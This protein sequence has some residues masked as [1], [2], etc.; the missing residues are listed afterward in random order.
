M[1]QPKKKLPRYNTTGQNCYVCGN[2]A[3]RY[4]RHLDNN[5]TIIKCQECGLEYTDPIPSEPVL[6]LFYEKYKDIRAD[7][8]I[9]E[10]NAHEHLKLLKKYGW[11]QGSKT[12]DFGAGTGVFVEV[13]G[14]NCYGVDLQSNSCPRIKQSLKEFSDI[15]WDFIVLWGVL[16]HLPNPQK[17]IC[18]LVDRLKM[19]GVLALTT[20][21]AEGVIPYYYKPPEHLSYWTRDALEILS[22][23]SGLKIVKCEPYH[24][25]QFS[26][27]YMQR[28]LSRTPEEYSRQISS[29]LQEIISIPTNEIRVVMR[30]VA[31]M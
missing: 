13:A 31:E 12:L 26:Y 29:N 24:M 30:K 11:T 25:F 17:S 20:I 23:K 2:P 18:E 9:V 14:Q 27:I 21:D 8:K 10:L 4:H 28:L 1:I 19:G 15:L 7:R 5:Y 6:E 22:K 16:E 3:G